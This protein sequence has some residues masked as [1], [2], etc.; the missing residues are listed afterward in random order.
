MIKQTGFDRRIFV[1]AVTSMTLA[2]TVGVAAAQDAKQVPA[3][4]PSHVAS[5][6]FAISNL[7]GSALLSGQ[8]RTMQS[9][10]DAKHSSLTSGRTGNQGAASGQKEILPVIV[11]NQ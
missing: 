3:Q 5:L 6:N 11:R 10:I 4:L 8:V 9:Q 2:A 7:D 1:S